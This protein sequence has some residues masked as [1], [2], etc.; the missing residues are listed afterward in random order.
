[1]RHEDIYEK[2]LGGTV[3]K[4]MHAFLKTVNLK[5]TK[6]LARDDREWKG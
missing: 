3:K 1:M 5:S 4:C 2:R 6:V